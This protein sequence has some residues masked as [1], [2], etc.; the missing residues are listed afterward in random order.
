MSDSSL[1]DEM[2]QL[3][4]RLYDIELCNG[5]NPLYNAFQSWKNGNQT[6]QELT[7][8]LYQFQKTTAR[9]LFLKYERPSFADINIAQAIV[10]GMLPIEELSEELQRF[11]SKK[12]QLLKRTSHE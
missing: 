5:L 1:Q 11:L 4:K 7:A 3:Q 6:A 12:I 2:L 9:E 8:Q 10:D